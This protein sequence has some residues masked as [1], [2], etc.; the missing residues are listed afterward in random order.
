MLEYDQSIQIFCRDDE[1]VFCFYLYDK[2]CSFQAA[3]QGSEIVVKQVLNNFE[4]FYF[5][6]PGRG[7]YSSLLREKPP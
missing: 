2:N 7:L 3:E 6:G 1:L 4:C 5:W